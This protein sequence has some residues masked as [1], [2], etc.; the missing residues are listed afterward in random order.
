M[1]IL[2]SKLYIIIVMVVWG[3]QSV[4]SSQ[5]E[6]KDEHNSM[7]DRDLNLGQYFFKEIQSKRGAED[8]LA[9]D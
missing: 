8:L 6:K 1:Y 7:A 4:N 5:L 3:G 2:S 9:A